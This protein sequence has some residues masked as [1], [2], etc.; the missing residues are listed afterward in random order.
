[1]SFDLNIIAAR[2]RSLEEEIIYKLINR[3]QYRANKNIYTPGLSGFNPE[4]E[5]SLFDLRLKYQEDM[6]AVF[7][8]FLVP[9][10]RPYHRNL[11]SSRRLVTQDK[12]LRLQDV[13]QVNL[14]GRV[15]E[16]YHNMIP[17]ICRPGDDGQYGSSVE[18]DI[19]AFQ[20]IM[21]RIHYGALYVAESKFRQNP[22]QYTSLIKKGD[23]SGLLNL[24]TRVEVEE[25]IYKRIEAKTAEIQKD[26]DQNLR[27]VLA[28][29]LMRELY[30]DHIIPLTKE[31]EILYLLQRLS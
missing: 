18:H 24:L 7:G 6:D 13:N 26:V 8:R 23:R 9:E 29:A 30:H 15:R 3:I 12:E 28:P 31:G 19:A 21:R 27:Q 5:L 2:L 1:M 17:D 22:D 25:A 14:A 11:P 10:E 20:A 4:E 16:V